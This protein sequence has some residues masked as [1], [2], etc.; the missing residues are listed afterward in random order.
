MSLRVAILDFDGTLVDSVGIKDAAFEALYGDL[1]EW[2]EIE[3]YHLA[4]NHTIR[5]E[6]F[7]AIDE[8]ILGVEHTPERA[9][10]I[11]ERFSALVADA[12]GTAPQVPGATELLDALTG[13]AV[14]AYLL[15]MS[16]ADELSRILAARGLA[17]RFADVYAHPWTK[18]GAVA[19]ILV[20]EGA[21]A[22]DALMIGDSPE[23]AEAAASAGVPFLG[24]D[25]GKP[26]PAGV[27]VVADM[28]GALSALAVEGAPGTLA[29]GEAVWTRS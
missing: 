21:D 5:F 8:E 1:P 10:E 26:F 12:I 25:S 19:D 27:P 23:D 16:P 4:N 18:T 17:D 15:S 22:R 11:A 14:R 20:R 29:G 24:C 13:A 2:P 3:S 28:R 6:K 9:R 7:R